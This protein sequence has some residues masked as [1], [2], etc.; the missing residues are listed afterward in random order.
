MKVI[1]V[2]FALITGVWAFSGCKKGGGG[3][4]N[5]PAEANLVVEIDPANGTVQAPSLGPFNLKITI[6]STMPPSGV[7]IEINAKK[8][9]GSGSTPYFTSAVNTSNSISN[10]NIVNTPATVQCLV[11]IKVTSLSKSS[12]QWSGSYRYSRK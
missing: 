6:T 10:F 11:E 8:D 5:P 2:F 7:K 4:N 12:N 3:G 9:D 1:A